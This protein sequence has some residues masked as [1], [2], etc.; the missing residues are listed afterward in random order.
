MAHAQSRAT[1]PCASLISSAPGLSLSNL[2]SLAVPESTL[3]SVA[4]DSGAD[5]LA[6]GKFPCW[7]SLVVGR[8]VFLRVKRTG[9]NAERQNHSKKEKGI[10]KHRRL[11]FHSPS[12]PQI[13]SD[14]NSTLPA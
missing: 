11:E 5:F 1:P 13:E 9:Q 10:A 4:A 14:S 7:G 2:P 12:T 3:A 6:A 8:R